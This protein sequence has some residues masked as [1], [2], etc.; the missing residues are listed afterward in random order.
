MAASALA[1]ALVALP[2]GSQPSGPP[3]PFEHR[4]HDRLSCLECHGSGAEHRLIR[5]RT[6]RDCASCHHDPRRELTCSTCHDGGPSEPLRVSTPMSRP[7]GGGSVTRELP[8]RH[9]VHLAASTT[10]TCRDCHRTEVTLARDRDCGSCHASHHTARAECSSCHPAPRGGAHDAGVHLSC[11]GAACHEPAKA[12]PPTLSRNLCLA[13][14]RRQATHEPGGTCADCH[15]IPAGGGV[16]R[17]GGR[18]GLD[19]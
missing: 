18:G 15:K 2:L 3:R 16:Q 5:V 1:L 8:F 12:P 13:C 9:E 11:A 7:G 17:G 14:H 6:P 10:L 4:R 19:A